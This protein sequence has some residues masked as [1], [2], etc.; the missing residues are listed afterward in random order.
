M[1]LFYFRFNIGFNNILEKIEFTRG[2]AISPLWIWETTKIINMETVLR[3]FPEKK[4]GIVT[5]LIE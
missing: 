1:V 2:S 4:I 5:E 3:I